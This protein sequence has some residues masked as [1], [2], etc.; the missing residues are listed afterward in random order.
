MRYTAMI[1]KTTLGVHTAMRGGKE[2]FTENVVD[3]CINR[4]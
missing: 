1:A 2:A 3:I 4:I